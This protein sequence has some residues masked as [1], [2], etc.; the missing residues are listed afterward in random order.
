MQPIVISSIER[1]GGQYGHLLTNLC[2]ETWFLF[3]VTDGR[4]THS[5][6]WPEREQ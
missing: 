1:Q 2:S 3:Y 6:V 5:I 4:N